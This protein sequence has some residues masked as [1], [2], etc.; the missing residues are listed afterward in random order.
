MP[1][2]LEVKIEQVINDEYLLLNLDYGM[3]KMKEY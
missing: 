2:I 1:E 3:V